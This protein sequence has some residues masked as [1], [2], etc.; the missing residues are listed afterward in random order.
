[1]A[2]VGG[3]RCDEGVCGVFQLLHAREFGFGRVPDLDRVDVRADH[4]F[5]MCGH[6]AAVNFGAGS[7]ASNA[8]CDLEDDAREAVL[9]D[10]Y[11][12]VVGNLSQF[13][14][15]CKVFRQVAGDGSAVEGSASVF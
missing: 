5:Q 2:G 6:G 4:V 8:L 7:G 15:I 3:L 11:F 1:M 9:V 13:A 10:P 12:L 14:D